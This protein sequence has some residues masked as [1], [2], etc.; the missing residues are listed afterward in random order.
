MKF[1][2]TVGKRIMVAAKKPS[3]LILLTRTGWTLVCFGFLKNNMQGQIGILAELHL[4]I[5]Q[6][7][8]SHY[9]STFAHTYGG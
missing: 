3:C 6:I 1:F 5:T 8:F 9:S 4:T 2:Y 7:V